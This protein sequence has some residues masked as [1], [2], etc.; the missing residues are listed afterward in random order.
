M[1]LPTIPQPWLDAISGGPFAQ[2]IRESTWAFATLESIHVVAIVLVV[3]SITIVDLRLIGIASNN[4]SVTEICEDTLKWTWGAFI[5]AA[6][7][8]VLMVMA[9]IGEYVVVPSFWLKFFFMFAAAVN[10]LIFQKLAFRRVADWDIDCAVPPAAK[11]AGA[12]SI[13]FWVLVVIFGRWIG[14][15]VGFGSVFGGGF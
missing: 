10:M 3:G 14:Y 4:C 12:L 8:G 11:L 2:Y 6:L 13:V 1:Y 9:K 15:T 7:S 5:I